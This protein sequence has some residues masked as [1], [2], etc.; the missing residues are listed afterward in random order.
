MHYILHWL[1]DLTGVIWVIMSKKNILHRL[2]LRTDVIYY[3]LPYFKARAVHLRT[4]SISHVIT[5]STTSN[6]CYYQRV[7]IYQPSP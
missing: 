4:I 1:D 7:S 3:F 5:T 2:L 6:V